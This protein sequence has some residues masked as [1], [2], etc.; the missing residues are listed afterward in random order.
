MEKINKHGILTPVSAKDYPKR[1][2]PL[3]TKKLQFQGIGLNQKPVDKCFLGACGL[4]CSSSPGYLHV[5]NIYL[6]L[7]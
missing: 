5:W 4:T 7:P 3:L 2:R 1:R 6:Y